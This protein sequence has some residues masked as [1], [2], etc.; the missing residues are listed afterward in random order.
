[1]ININHIDKTP[2]IIT[3]NNI[4]NLYFL[5]NSA[6]S[7]NEIKRKEK[8]FNWTYNNINIENEK[9]RIDNFLNDLTNEFKNCNY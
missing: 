9:L 8:D 3:K 7:R 2:E 1:M 6:I 4:N 5:K